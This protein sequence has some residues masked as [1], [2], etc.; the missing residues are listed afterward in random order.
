MSNIGFDFNH[1]LHMASG[2]KKVKLYLV[3]GKNMESKKIIKICLIGTQIT[4]YAVG[5][6]EKAVLFEEK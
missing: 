5:L 3:L 1:T 6:Q 2:T 4:K